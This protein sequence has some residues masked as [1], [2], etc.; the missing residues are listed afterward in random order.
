M[1]EARLRHAPAGS[2]R[3]IHVPSLR[4]KECSMKGTQDTR[5]IERYTALDIHK[6]YVLAGGH[7][8]FMILRETPTLAN[9]RI[10]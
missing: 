2:A 4:H 5:Q 3:E 6:E 9:K 1:M 7:F 8:R 10:V